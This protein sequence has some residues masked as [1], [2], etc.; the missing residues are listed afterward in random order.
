MRA[1]FRTLLAIAVLCAAGCASPEAPV[2]P[3][4]A[5]LGDSPLPGTIGIL[6]NRGAAGVIVA[7]VAQGSPAAEA[8]LHVGD[9]VLRYNGVSI[10]DSDQF[11]RMM[12]DSAP[13]STAQVEL[14]RADTVLR[15]RVPVEQI[16][17]AWRA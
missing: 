16:D 3:R 2:V 9:I 8:G 17:T 14:L 4:H 6:V 15:L 5:R 7:A 11:Y 13:G 10:T 12:L 1:A